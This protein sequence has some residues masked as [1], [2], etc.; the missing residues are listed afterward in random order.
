M[1]IK[2]LIVIFILSISPVFAAASPG[3]D[4]YFEAL[5]QIKEVPKGGS[6]IPMIKSAEALQQIV[7][8]LTN[9]GIKNAKVEDGVLYGALDKSSPDAD[10]DE[11]GGYEVY[12]GNISNDGSV[13]YEFIS[14]DERLAPSAFYKQVGDQLVLID[15]DDI[16]STNLGDDELQDLAVAQLLGPYT[17]NGKVYLRY[18]YHPLGHTDY[19]KTL[20]ST[21]SYLLEGNKIS[22]NGPHYNFS[23]PKMTLAEYSGS[24]RKGDDLMA[25]EVNKSCGIYTINSHR[26]AF[27]VKYKKKQYFDAYNNLK[28]FVALCQNQDASQVLWMKNDLLLAL[29]KMKDPATCGALGKEIMDDSG[30]KDTTPAFKKAMQFNLDLCKKL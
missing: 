16:I 4:T 26:K 19:D 12:K 11:T 3:T 21:C 27:L 24:C 13:I 30:Y 28:K 29:I 17:K 22:A 9:S 8:L 2:A 6:E 20:L 23:G 25:K 1:K 14:R 18:M 10:F 7:R 15:L 5:D